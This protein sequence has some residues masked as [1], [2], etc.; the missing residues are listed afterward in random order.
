MKYEQSPGEGLSSLTQL[1]PI[2]EG[3]FVF[4]GRHLVNQEFVKRNPEESNSAFV[5]LTPSDFSALE[6]RN[7]GLE[8][9]LIFSM[10]VPSGFEPTSPQ[11]V[12]S[13]HQE[14]NLPLMQNSSRACVLAACEEDTQ[15]VPWRI[16]KGYGSTGNGL[17][18]EAISC[19]SLHTRLRQMQSSCMGEKSLQQCS[20][21]FQAPSGKLVSNLIQCVATLGEERMRAS[22]LGD[23]GET[24]HWKASKPPVK[25]SAR[26]CESRCD[27]TYDTLSI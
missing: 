7:K 11:A 20:V 18:S 24:Y 23:N 5:S 1:K 21:Y 12:P 25:S 15:R 9:E 16:A 26:L 6:D 19:A 4:N 14:I 8:I 13:L 10:A 2:V 17:S 27:R 22:L 3:D